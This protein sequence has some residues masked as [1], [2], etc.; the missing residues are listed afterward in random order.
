[1]ARLVEGGQLFDLPEHRVAASL[2]LGGEASPRPEKKV[3][4]RFVP[5]DGPAVVEEEGEIAGGR[6]EEGDGGADPSS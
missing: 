1:M 2:Q 6:R 4:P 5:E 3:G